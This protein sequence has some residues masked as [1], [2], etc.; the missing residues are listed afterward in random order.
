M[1]AQRPEFTVRS[2]MRPIASPLVWTSLA[3]I[4]VLAALVRLIGI[5]RYPGLIYDEYYYVPAADVLLGRKSPVS[6]PHAVAGIDP[7]L[8][9]H[10]P[11][12]KEIIALAIWALGNHPWVWR[13][14]GAMLGLII[15][16]ILFALGTSLFRSHR[17]GLF[18]AFL[19]AVDGLL[20]SLS[21]VALPDG[22]AVPLVA[23]NMYFL[24]RLSFRAREGRPV[25]VGRLLLWGVF[26]GLG[27]S[28]KWIGAQTIL[29]SWIWLLFRRR[30]LSRWWWWAL[31]VTVVPFLTY[32]MTY[33][34]SWPSGF[35]QSWLPA[36]PLPAFFVL[37]W[38]ML[39]D[40]WTLRF[41]HPWTSNAFS[42]LGLPRPTA[43]LILYP[44]HETIRVWS[45][46]NPLTVWAGTIASV[47]GWARAWKFG[48]QRRAW[49]FLA[50]WL[51]VFYGTWLLTPR[52]KFTYY[53]ASAEMGVIV[54]LA[55][56]TVW[57]AERLGRWGKV[58]GYGTMGLIGLSTLY[59]LP[60]WT[61]MPTPR[62]GYERLWWPP[63]WN[64]RPKPAAHVS[65]PTVDYHP[66]R[67][68]LTE[69]KGV[70]WLGGQGISGY[71]LHLSAPV[72]G[73]VSGNEKTVFV[74]AENGLV[75][76]INRTDG[77]V[78]WSEGL[79][80]Q[81]WG[82]PVLVGSTVIVGLGN[83]LFRGYGPKTGWVR[84]TGVNGLMGLSRATGRVLW[85]V[86]TRGEDMARPAVSGQVVYEVTGGGRL[87]AVN[88]GTGHLLWSL[89]I[90]GFDTYSA[91]LIQGHTL[92]V[93]TNLYRHTF[94]ATRS[95]VTAVNLK[96]HKIQW[97]TALSVVSG[98][99]DGSV[100]GADGL[101][102]A[103]GVVKMA[104]S[105]KAT[106]GPLIWD[107]LFA[108]NAQTGRT[109][110]SANLGSGRVASGQAEVANPAVGPG[111][112]V[113]GNPGNRYVFSYAENSGRLLW[114]RR[115][116]GAV[117]E[118]PTVL[119]SS[120]LVADSRGAVSRLS[121]RTG[122][123]E[124]QWQAGLGPWT[125]SFRVAPYGV[126]AGTGQGWLAVG[127]PRTGP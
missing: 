108:L 121:V 104:N 125:T 91:P 41:Y 85:F 101:I 48:H 64:P 79:P 45:F 86:K 84:G 21:R 60:L 49:G 115:V 51:A 33:A 94:P 20:I 12:A 56:I 24:W 8:L 63:S 66:S 81:I 55:G 75:D 36:N 98:L 89:T 96:S 102:F 106:S 3:A 127:I 72:R 11:L 5:G 2:T 112:V 28:A 95:W 116:P 40:M 52:S 6:L 62:P 80:N 1:A 67:R 65:L 16:P 50:L 7:N 31:S 9:S 88:A 25:P 99:S 57:A 18:A 110:W 93:A 13:L 27:F 118:A 15:P 100:A 70:S 23:V 107:R 69:W 68:A 4:E 47:T 26:L 17:A 19:G 114:K 87:I 10:P 73:T 97:Q 119:P 82:G 92:Y 105:P 109:V 122:R 124:A 43:F 120:L 76:A 58:A 83:P 54:A 53:F 61:G 14:P 77:H 74:A 22:V 113:V 39:K 59:L 32:F 38:L 90:G 44:R 123:I 42:W 117:I 29:A 126:T 111:M 103:V 35:H 78:L 30:D 46:A 34:Y 37:Q 71:A